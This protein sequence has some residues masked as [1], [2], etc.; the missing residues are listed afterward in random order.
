MSD[1]RF[2]RKI[3]D[4]VCEHCGAVVTGNGYRNHCPHC[5]YSKHVD[6]YPGDRLASCHGLMKVAEVFLKHGQYVLEHRCLVCG[7]KKR[8]KLQ[9]DDDLKMLAKY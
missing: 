4:F 2:Q 7:H 3:E 5:L 6:V 9:T 1:R 8:N